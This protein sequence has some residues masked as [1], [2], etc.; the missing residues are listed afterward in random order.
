MISRQVDL[1]YSMVGWMEDYMYIEKVL[2]YV[3]QFPLCLEE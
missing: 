3:C 1:I 2:E